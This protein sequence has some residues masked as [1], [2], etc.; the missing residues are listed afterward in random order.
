MN[1]TR[2][3]ALLFRFALAAIAGLSACSDEDGGGNIPD[4]GDVTGPGS[5]ALRQQATLSGPY[6]GGVRIVANGLDASGPGQEV[7]LAFELDDA[8]QVRQFDLI[9]EADPPSAFDMASAVAA[10]QQPFVTPLPT[11]VQVDGGSL[12][13]IGASLTTSGTGTQALATLRLPTSS[14]FGTFSRAR[15]VV[16]LLSIGPASAQRDEYGE[17][18]RLGVSLQ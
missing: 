5:Q 15:L 7:S 2:S 16:T 6:A 4:P 3:L 12:R 1:H 11:G 10:V 13:V 18:L 17:S 8:D 9:V 14:S